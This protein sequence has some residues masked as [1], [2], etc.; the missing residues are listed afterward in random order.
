MPLGYLRCRAVQQ[1]SQRLPRGAALQL[2]EHVSDAWWSYS[3][4]DRS[5]VEA[6]LSAVL[7]YPAPRSMGREVFRNFGRYLVE[8]FTMHRG[9]P[10]RLR[11]EG[12]GHLDAAHRAGG[13]IIL[14]GHLGN[15]ELGA[16]CI[17]MMGF[18]MSVVARPHADAR[19]DALFN[20]QR[21]LSGL[22]VIPVGAEAARQ[23]LAS[24]RQGRFLGLLGDR[25]FGAHGMRLP[26]FGGT[27]MLPDGPALLSLRSRAPILPS[28]L[29]REGP[30]QFCLHI[31]PPMRPQ[32]RGPLAAEVAA[33]T[34]AYTEIFERY[35]QQDPTQ[36]LM[37]QPVISKA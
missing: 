35:I 31:E 34:K 24:L 15:W 26:W 3:A 9:S 2:A 22:E 33:L 30:G 29:L 25:E 4:R 21:Q 10:Q 20:R 1:L 13:A 16:A 6:N 19:I 8:F 27:A 18:P 23:S 32:A 28:V 7:G 5:A 17:R 36:W 37:F 12:R 14:T 11:V